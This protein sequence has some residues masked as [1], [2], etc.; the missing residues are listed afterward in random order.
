MPGARSRPFSEIK[1][2]AAGTAGSQKN[3]GASSAYTDPISAWAKVREAAFAPPDAYRLR[4]R[5]CYAGRRRPPTA[6]GAGVR[7]TCRS[8]EQRD[9]NGRIAVNLTRR[10]LAAAGVLTLSAA[11]LI[12]PAMAATDD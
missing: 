1:T 2:I 9:Y 12:V 3:E 10:D 7:R 8:D 11:T 6:A 5:S 4:A